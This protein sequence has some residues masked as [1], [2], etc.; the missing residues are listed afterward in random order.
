[1]NN[2]IAGN[3]K[4]NMNRAEAVRL[5]EQLR[6][7]EAD[8]DVLVCPPFIHLEAVIGAL[9]GKGDVMVG[10]QDCSAYDNGAR[11]GDI[12]AVMIA[13]I[14][15]GYVILGHSERRQYYAETDSIVKEKVSQAHA[16]KL[17]TIVC[18]G[19]TE[20]QREQGKAEDTVAEQLS[21]SLP[22]S[23]TSNN[24]IIAYEPVWAIGSGKTATPEDAEAMHKFI[25][26]CLQDYV[27]GPDNI[28]ILYGGSMKP[29]NAAALLAQPNING[30]L[31]GGASLDIDSFREIVS[32]ASLE[33]RG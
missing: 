16:N 7:I 29:G 9:D 19:E 27:D 30:G 4:M 5:S 6:D 25:R 23:A 20:D 33:Q 26:N 18:V 32:L 24:T 31:I 3:W 1:M 2:L 14:G 12:S 8:V 22:S 15:A 17:V 28:R 10:A 21:G 13:D 11:T